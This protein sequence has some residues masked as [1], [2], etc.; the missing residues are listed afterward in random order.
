VLVAAVG[1]L[2]N[3]GY[4]GLSAEEAIRAAGIAKPLRRR[5]FVAGRR[6][7]RTMLAQVLGGRPEDLALDAAAGLPPRLASR[8]DLHLSVSHS[9]EWVA[10]AIADRPVGIDIEA[11]GARRD[12]ERFARWV[13]SPEEF[14]AWCACG[15]T[16]ADDLLIAHWTRKEAWL[17]REGGE[18]LLT[19]MHRL[20]AESREASD[21]DVAT[22]RVGDV[23]MLSLCAI[24]VTEVAVTAGSDVALRALG[25]FRMS[26]LGE[27]A[28]S[29]SRGA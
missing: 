26:D 10:A 1:S 16:E 12:P 4:A 7:L 20:H 19:R 14:A 29:R 2:A 28:P 25:T 9:G 6:L 3:P 24:G 27:A 13:C 8:P 22:W 11:L 15:R 18:V 5:Q 21:A 23:A 17:K